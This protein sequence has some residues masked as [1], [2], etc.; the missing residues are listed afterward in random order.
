[1]GRAGCGVGATPPQVQRTSRGWGRGEG[2]VLESRRKTQTVRGPLPP[3][4][5]GPLLSLT[6][7]NRYLWST[8][9]VPGLGP[10]AASRRAVPDPLASLPGPSG[11]LCAAF[12]SGGASREGREWGVGGGEGQRPA[13]GPAHRLM[14]TTWPGT[15][16]PPPAPHRSREHPRLMRAP[17]PPHTSPRGSLISLHCDW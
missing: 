15:R 16:S 14:E 1:M 5:P 11:S 9:P 12:L 7:S 13:S 2:E 4:C 8:Y 10:T 3:P 17:A 6:S